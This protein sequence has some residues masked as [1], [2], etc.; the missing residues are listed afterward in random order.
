MLARQQLG[1]GVTHVSRA[2]ADGLAQKKAPHRAGRGRE[3]HG[4]RG[5]GLKAR[6][7]AATAADARRFR[8]ELPYRDGD[9]CGAQ[10]LLLA[11]S[12][13]FIFLEDRNNGAGGWYYRFVTHGH[14][15]YARQDHNLRPT[16]RRAAISGGYLHA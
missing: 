12:R 3:I 13:Q 8:A 7:A 5:E 2:G 9:Q 14:R 11:L 4:H 10:D 1:M 16:E 6:P 15:C